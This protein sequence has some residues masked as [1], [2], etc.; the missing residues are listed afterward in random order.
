M[1]AVQTSGSNPGA[2]LWPQPGAVSITDDIAAARRQKIRELFDTIDFIP[3]RPAAS[4][5][6]TLSKL[7]YSQFPVETSPNKQVTWI[8][9]KPPKSTHDNIKARRIFCIR[10]PNNTLEAL[11]P[12]RHVLKNPFMKTGRFAYK[13]IFNPENP[14]DFELKPAFLLTAVY[15]TSQGVKRDEVLRNLFDREVNLRLHLNN[16]NSHFP[17]LENW[18][19]KQGRHTNIDHRSIS[20]QKI[21]ME[22]ECME[23][24]LAQYFDRNP[25]I[26]EKEITGIII[27]VLEAL[28]KMYQGGTE[29]GFVHC[30][31]KRENIILRR[32]EGKWV[33]YLTDVGLS[34]VIG[35]EETS[36][37]TPTELPPE[38]FKLA[39]HYKKT[40]YLQSFDLWTVGILA[41]DMLHQV[42]KPSQW[43]EYKKAQYNLAYARLHADD[44]INVDAAFIKVFPIHLYNW[45]Q[46]EKE[47]E[48]FFRWLKEKTYTPDLLFDWLKMKWR[49]EG[50]KF[51]ASIVQQHPT[52]T[53]LHGLLRLNP[54]ERHSVEQSLQQ[55]R[56]YHASLPDSPPA[57]LQVSPAAHVASPSQESAEKTDEVDQILRSEMHSE[58]MVP[59]QNN[60]T[61]GSGWWSWITGWKKNTTCSLQ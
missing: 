6:E 54:A 20:C 45:E 42:H 22:D 38:C 8:A 7:H 24:N 17:K 39:I 3:D 44:L 48:N 43:N 16:L 56:A 4:V 26:S 37:G 14:L 51:E 32:L 60:S 25:N 9:V 19:F 46:G 34:T 49:E 28:E 2:P 35:L 58:L 52:M 50:K 41:W 31:V 55:L 23:L 12:V 47:K 5:L 33:A 29:R 40:K 57:A 61:A 18:G 59:P 1:Q 53:W 11:M 15:P 30:D 27:R 13:V 21:M 10:R 36:K